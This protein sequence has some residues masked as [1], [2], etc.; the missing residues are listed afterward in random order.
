MRTEKE[1]INKFLHQP[2]KVEA[3]DIAN[4]QKNLESFPYFQSLQCV[5]LK[6]LFTNNSFQYNSQLRKTAAITTSRSILF[7]FITSPEFRQLEIAKQVQKNQEEATEELDLGITADQADDIANPDF[8]VPKPKDSSP[9]EFSE[10]EKYSFHQWL[11]LTKVSPIHHEQS[12][13]KAE[14][15]SHQPKTEQKSQP[16]QDK[17][18]TF[19]KSNPKIKPSKNYTPKKEIRL[20][21]SPSSELMTETLARV[22]EEQKAYE[23][24]IQA[25]KI[26]ILNNPEKNSFF[27][28]QIER[29]EQILENNT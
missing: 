25:Y 29:L 16:K 3:T 14:I 9:L 20:K 13:E 12:E 22:Y 26:L 2:S 21:T 7:D 19:L 24:A 27:A 6:V 1:K 10:K 18:D 23:K 28:T 11:Q 15:S 4:L 8:F 5:Y 17:I